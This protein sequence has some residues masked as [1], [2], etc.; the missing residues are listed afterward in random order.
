MPRSPPVYRSPFGLADELVRLERPRARLRSALGWLIWLAKGDV[1]ADRG[2]KQRG[3]L[4]HD[5]NLAAQEL[6]SLPDIHPIRVMR[7]AEGRKRG[8]RLTTVVLPEP[9]GPSSA[10]TGR[11]ALK[12]ISFSTELCRRTRKLR[13]RSDVT[14]AARP[15]AASLSSKSETPGSS[16]IGAVSR[17]SNALGEAAAIEIA[18][19]II[20]KKR[21]GRT[22]LRHVGW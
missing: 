4:Q 7:P 17:I 16:F 15:S 6:R 11:A 1:L 3:L 13:Y 2:R 10:I 21:T 22:Q 12:L 8:I 18:G 9:V 20:P 19:R 5:A 14:T